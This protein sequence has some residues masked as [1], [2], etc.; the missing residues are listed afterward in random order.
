MCARSWVVNVCVRLCACPCLLWRC[1]VSR[2]TLESTCASCRSVPRRFHTARALQIHCTNSHA[3][4]RFYPEDTGPKEGD[5]VT[6]ALSKA[7]GHGENDTGSVVASVLD[8]VVRRVEYDAASTSERARMRYA[9][10]AGG[11]GGTRVQS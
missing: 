9:R 1:R 3:P 4:F 2:P 7:W 6:G 5:R 10:G 8:L 11:V